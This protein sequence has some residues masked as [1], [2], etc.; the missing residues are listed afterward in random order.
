[1]TKC[2]DG[3]TRLAIDEELPPHGG[4]GF[5]AFSRLLRPA[6]WAR[7]AVGGPGWRART[8]V[9]PDNRRE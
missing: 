3:L 6:R 8:I 1:M 5:C 4:D 9:G 2:P 7:E